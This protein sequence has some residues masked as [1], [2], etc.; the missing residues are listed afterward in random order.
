ME[1]FA[2]EILKQDNVKFREIISGKKNSQEFIDAIKEEALEKTDALSFV[3][4]DRNALDVIV[5]KE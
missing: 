2:N 5:W 3:E 4:L 1:I